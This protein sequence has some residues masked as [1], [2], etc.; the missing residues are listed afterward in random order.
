MVLSMLTKREEHLLSW[1]LIRAGE[2]VERERDR[3]QIN[4]KLDCISQVEE[5]KIKAEETE[6]D[7][8]WGYY[9]FR[10]GWDDI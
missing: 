5:N 1:E 3:Q 7:R 10:E 8:G 6:N 2:Q 9:Y 4:D